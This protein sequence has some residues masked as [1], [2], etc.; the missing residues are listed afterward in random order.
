[1]IAVWFPNDAVIPQKATCN[2]AVLKELIL[3][4]LQNAYLFSDEKLSGDT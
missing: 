3:Y 1:M 2:R 4:Q